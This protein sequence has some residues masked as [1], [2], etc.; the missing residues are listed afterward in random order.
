MLQTSIGWAGV[1]LP[2]NTHALRRPRGQVI[3][4]GNQ[5]LHLALNNLGLMPDTQ[6]CKTGGKSGTDY[7]S[8]NGGGGPRKAWTNRLSCR[9]RSWMLR[10]LAGVVI[11]GLW[12]LGMLVLQMTPETPYGTE[13]NF[14]WMSNSSAVPAESMPTACS[15]KPCN[16]YVIVFCDKTHFRV[17]FYF[18]QSKEQLSNNYAVSSASWYVIPVRYA[19]SIDELHLDVYFSMNNCICAQ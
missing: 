4:G 8:P 1:F 12:L 5:W 19:N 16:L 9:G 15:I 3:L 10:S 13:M 6:G 11:L 2:L 17:V 7:Q 18:E 14:S